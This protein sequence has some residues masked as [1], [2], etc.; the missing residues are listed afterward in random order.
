MDSDSFAGRDP[1]TAKP[2]F[3]DRVFAW[4]YDVNG[5]ADASRRRAL[6]WLDTPNARVVAA[7]LTVDAHLFEALLECAR[8]VIHSTESLP[9]WQTPGHAEQYLRAILDSCAQ[10]LNLTEEQT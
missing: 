4:F 2:T 9:N 7:R 8:N 1:T 5:P 3:T 10:G 6:A